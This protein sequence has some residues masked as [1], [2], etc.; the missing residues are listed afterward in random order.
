MKHGRYDGPNEALQGKTALLRP[1]DKD[2]TVLAQFDDVGQRKVDE[3]SK[4]KDVTDL[5]Q[6]MFGW[7]EFPEGDFVNSVSAKKRQ[8]RKDADDGT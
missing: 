4:A 5:E 3:L 7:H 8:A 6:L 1:S 2:A